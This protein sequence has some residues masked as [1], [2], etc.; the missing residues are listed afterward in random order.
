[1]GHMVQHNNFGEMLTYVDEALKVLPP[2]MKVSY[3][4]VATDNA[5]V[6]QLLDSAQLAAMAAGCTVT[7]VW[8]PDGRSCILHA[9]GTLVQLRTWIATCMR[10]MDAG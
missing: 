8:D 1:M 9:T 5:D 10:Y 7:Y 6:I 4:V 2:D 3:S